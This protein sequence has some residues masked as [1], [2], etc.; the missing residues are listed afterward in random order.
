MGEIDLK[1]D[2]RPF[3]YGVTYHL[4][5]LLE[6]QSFSSASSFHSSGGMEPTAEEQTK[7]ERKTRKN[8]PGFSCSRSILAKHT[9]HTFSR[10]LRTDPPS[11]TVPAFHCLPGDIPAKLTDRLA[12][13]QALSL[14]YIVT[15]SAVGWRGH[16]NNT[17]QCEPASQ[18]RQT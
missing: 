11:P 9:Q 6:R 1:A 5:W 13:W 2:R 18:S 17:C 4:S 15:S 14:Y 7:N 12:T 3:L 8:G 10:R 16:D